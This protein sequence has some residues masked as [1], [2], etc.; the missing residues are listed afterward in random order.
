MEKL[1]AWGVH[2]RQLLT[3]IILSKNIKFIIVTIKYFLALIGRNSKKKIQ[4]SYY[5]RDLNK[6]ASLDL[7]FLRP[8]IKNLIKVSN[9]GRFEFTSIE[10]K[11]LLKK[12]RTLLKQYP[13]IF[14]GEKHAI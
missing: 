2:L 5:V 12:S 8:K 3:F 10:S 13:D 6:N 9:F 7:K 4:I 1:F 14:V 11:K